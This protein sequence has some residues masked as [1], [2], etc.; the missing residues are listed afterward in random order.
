M[1]TRATYIRS[2]ADQV[3]Q[4]IA[5]FNE[6]VLPATKGAKGYVGATLLYNREQ[7]IAMGATIWESARA[8]AESE[9]IGTNSRIQAASET[10]ASIVNVERGEVVAMERAGPPKSPG[11][12]RMVRT[13]T[14]PEKLDQLIGFVRDKAVPKIREQKGFRSVWSIADHTTGVVNTLTVWESAADR[15]TS[16]AALAGIRDEASRLSGSPIRMEEYEQ[17]VVELRAPVTAS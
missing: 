9:E 12:V 13:N 16:K 14:D 8:M 4:L 3:E 2:P 5:N 17:L 11:F 15:E 7:G 6:K 10:R 1:H